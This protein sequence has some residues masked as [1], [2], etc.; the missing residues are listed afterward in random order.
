MDPQSRSQ[1]VYAAVIAANPQSAKMT[2]DER[3][4]LQVA[5]KTVFGADLSYILANAEIP[6]AQYQAPAG[7]SVATT[8]GPAAQS[9]TVTS[10]T[11]I[12]GTGKIL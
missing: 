12:T 11:T 4:Q 10:P 6:G 7:A 8:G 2:A 1:A 9:G 5:L 3:S